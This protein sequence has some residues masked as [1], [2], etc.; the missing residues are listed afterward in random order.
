MLVLF[1]AIVVAFIAIPSVII[2]AMATLILCLFGLCARFWLVTLAASAVAMLPFG[3]MFCRDVLFR[4]PCDPRQLSCSG[5]LGGVFMLFVFYLA[6][7][8][9][10]PVA[11][12]ISRAIVRAWKDA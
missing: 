1:L 3:Y 8:I 10:G 6:I 2:A 9:G 12:L 5:E 7:P 11:W 4:A